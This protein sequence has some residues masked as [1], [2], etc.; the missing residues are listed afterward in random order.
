ML[1]KIESRR[2]R[3]WQK[4]RWLDGITDSVEWVWAN[5]WRWWRK[6]KPGMLQSTGSQKVGHDWATEQQQNLQEFRIVRS[7]LFLHSVCSMSCFYKIHKGKK[8]KK[9]SS[10]HPSC[11]GH[12]FTL[13]VT[14]RW[15]WVWVNSGSWWWT[16]RPGVLRFMGSQRVGHDWAT[17]LNINLIEI[18]ACFKKKKLVCMDLFNVLFIVL[19]PDHY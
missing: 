4:T 12:C 11:E 19:W 14:T 6:G 17:E 2:R 18:F 3:G 15:T 8:K 5:S 9:R 7:L 16:G 13:P 1:G 10:P